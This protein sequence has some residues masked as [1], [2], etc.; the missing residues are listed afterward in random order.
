MVAFKRALALGLAVTALSQ[1]SYASTSAVD[2]TDK[3]AKASPKLAQVSISQLANAS[4]VIPALAPKKLTFKQ[5]FCSAIKSIFS[6]VSETTAE[7]A[8]IAQ[9][10]MTVA[11]GFVD[12]KTQA[13]LKTAEAGLA[14]GN[15]DLQAINVKIQADASIKEVAAEATKDTTQMLNTVGVNDPTATKILTAATKVTA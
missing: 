5:K 13:Q 11:E 1:V 3:A 15:A 9:V 14:V 8:P 10:G 4:P 12:A 6:C 2:L 7:L